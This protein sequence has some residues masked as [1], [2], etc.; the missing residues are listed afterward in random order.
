MGLGA[1]GIVTR[2]TLDIEPTFEVRQDV[3]TG[4][5]WDSLLANFDA[6]TSSAY[7]VSVFTNWVG[8][9]VGSVWL[10][11]RTGAGDP[12]EQLF[13]AE[14]QT[15][16]LHPLPDQPSANTTVQGGVPGPWSDRL[17]HFKLGFTPSNGD[18]LQSEY[19]L[20][21]SEILPALAALRGLSDRIAPLLLISEIRTMAGDDL[22]LSGAFGRETVGIHF[23]W[24]M[25]PAEVRD[26]LPEIEARLLPLGA[27]PH[28]GKVFTA[29]SAQIAPLYPKLG[30][31]RALV[32][33][34][35]PQRVFGNDFLARTLGV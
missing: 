11:S 20:P 3:F 4:L 17:A 22:W 27:R 5:G 7:S 32:R 23:T 18:E 29:D 6:V 24:K 9:T 10:K 12:P 1:L 15:T 28:W 21:R 26:L 16:D 30:E 14:R 13:G 25:L 34:Y 2:M 19:L 8:D 31:F 35:D 33:R